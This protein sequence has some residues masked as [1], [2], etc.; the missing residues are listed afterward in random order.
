MRQEVKD[1]LEKI[2]GVKD[3]ALAKLE[4]LA[5]EI[6]QDPHRILSCDD[7]AIIQMQIQR[8]LGPHGY[9]IDT[10]SNAETAVDAINSGDYGLAIVDINIPG[11]DGFWLLDQIRTH[12]ITKLLLTGLV[13]DKELEEK[14]AELGAFVLSKDNLGQ[15]LDTVISVLPPTSVD[16]TTQID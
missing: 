7:D 15:L 9:I 1:I 14:A 4:A 11:H 8:Q 12:H 6:V 2:N 10:V 13:L 3:S 16:S 5:D